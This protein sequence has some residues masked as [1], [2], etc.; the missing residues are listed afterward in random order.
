MFDNLLSDLAGALQETDN[1]DIDVNKVENTATVSITKKDGTT[2]SVQVFDGDKGDKGDKGEKGDTGSIGPQGPQGPQGIQG[3]MGPQGKAFTISK[4]YSSISEMNA[5]FDNMQVGDYVMIASSVELEDN[6]KL[7]VK[8]EEEWLFVSD[9]SGGIQGIQGETGNGIATIQKTSTSGLI[10]TYTITYTD[11]NTS[12]FS[13]TNGKDGEDGEVSQ[14]QLDETNSHLDNLSKVSNLFGKITA[15]GTSVTLNDTSNTI[16]KLTLDTITSSQV[17][18]TGKNLF[19]ESLLSTSINGGLTWKY[20]NQKIK[21]SGTATR[22][23]SQSEKANINLQA[24]TYAFT[25]FSDSNLNFGVWLYNSNNQLIANS[26]LNNPFTINE[27]ATSIGLFVEGLTVNTAYNLETNIQIERNSS[28]GTYEPYTGGQPA[29]NP[30]YPQE[31]HVIKGNNEIKISNKNLLKI[32]TF[33][34]DTTTKTINGITA[35]IKDGKIHISGTSSAKTTFTLKKNDFTVSNRFY[36]Y[37]NSINS[38][39]RLELLCKVDGATK[40]LN[41]FSAPNFQNATTSFEYTS[42]YVVVENGQTVNHTFTPMVVEG[43]TL[44]QYEPYK[45]QTYPINLGDIEFCKI[46]DYKD[47][48]FK[49]TINSEYYNSS[50]ELNKWYKLGN[51]GKIIYDGSQ[52]ENWI[53]RSLSGDYLRAYIA[54]ENASNLQND[55]TSGVYKVKCD[56]L[57]CIPYG[58]QENNEN[59]GLYTQY[60]YPSILATRVSEMSIDGFREWLSQNNLTVYYVLA[61]P[62]Y[63]LLNDTLQTQLN[64]LQYALAYD[65]QTN[66]SQTNTDLPFII[67]AETYV[68]LTDYVKNTDYASTNKGGVIKTAND[69]ATAVNQDG[70]LYAKVDTYSDY[71]SRQNTLFISKGT[72]ENVITGKNLETSNNKVTSIS[73]SST[74]VQYPSAKCVYD[75][76]TQLKNN[77]ENVS[78][79]VTALENEN[80]HVYG[81]KRKITNNSSS[82]WERIKDS[83]SLIANATKNGETVQNN[84]DDLAP[85]SEIKSCNYDLTTKEINAWFG[86]PNFKFDGTNGDVFT[87]IPKTYWSIYQEND[88]DYVL[89]ADYPRAGFIEVDGFFVGRYNGAVVDDVLH[90]YSGLVPTTNKTIG[91]FRTLA[92]A[93]G[94]NFSQLDWRYF[95]LQMLYLVEY[96]NYNSQSMLGN[97]VMNRKY[98]KTIVAENNTNRAVIGSASGYY[99]GQIIRIGTSDGGT[100]VADARKITAIEA[101]DDGTVTGSALTFDGAAVNIAVDNFVCTMAQETGQCDTLGMKS[102]CL[103]NDGY[104]SMI[105]RGVENIFANIWQWVDG[106][107][108][109]DRLAYICKDH[110]KYASDKFDGDYKPLAYTN[111]TSNGNPKTL[112]LDVDEPFFRFPTEIGGGSSTYMC[113]YYY[114]NTGNRVARVSG[115]FDV[116]TGDGLWFWGFVN[117]SSGASWGVGCRVLIDNQ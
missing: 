23:Y 73:S 35:T 93:L 102:G 36:Y 90:T 104:H 116:G 15:T 109:K 24:G 18:T 92:N 114:Q 80:H 96:A 49:N 44:S 68:D 97:G 101:Y 85:W 19:N 89:L 37:C 100:Q 3:P 30:S 31:I 41:S 48:L 47:V 46:G 50:L 20:E 81:I 34:D 39:T 8:G 22:D 26:K 105:Y 63:T 84:F 88:Y 83:V 77:I 7:Y 29:P 110:S 71:N 94:D 4:T 43:S 10:D 115:S 27:E 64:T 6:A 67:D 59:L 55:I 86:D 58:Y 25:L 65:T 62:T 99:V 70:K 12:T 79:R 45:Q 111:C 17:T 61:T 72:L 2:K 103:N 21:L 51:V 5:D 117:A 16:M 42:L 32:T 112:G 56:K 66:I 9:F 14:E 108:V 78:I 40:Y 54:L 1:I 113:D 33:S 91:A 52:D 75:N 57:R 28:T 69:C 76:E 98:V 106:I 95:V 13:I 11:G 82:S 53:A 60:I 107:N 38:A 87:Y 74:D